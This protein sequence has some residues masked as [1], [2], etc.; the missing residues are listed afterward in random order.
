MFPSKSAADSLLEVP[1]HL[2]GLVS[3]IYTTLMSLKSARTDKIQS[4]WE[5]EL[6]VD[7]SV[8]FWN[9][10]LRIV[11]G[12]TSYARLNLM[13]FK[14][15]HGMHLSRTRIA[16]FNPT[17]EKT[18]IRCHTGEADLNHMFWTSPTLTAN[19]STMCDT[20]SKV[21]EAQLKPCVEFAIFGVPDDKSNLTQRQLNI[22]AFASLLARRHILLLW[23]STNPPKAS[24][25]LQHLMLY[26]HLEKITCSIRGSH[27]FSYVWQPLLPYFSAINI[28]PG[29]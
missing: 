14:V 6:G 5:K 13:Q 7:F 19:W 16:S 27:K 20:L 15:L 8:V 21:C 17:F 24:Y 22:I 23:K 12:S 1:L 3:R 11:N 25:W 26:L 2:Q 4:R 9:N 18:C 29:E 10:A 28:L